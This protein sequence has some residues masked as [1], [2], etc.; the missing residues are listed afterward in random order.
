[1]IIG[2]DPGTKR[3]G[4]A[5]ADEETR[6]AR[7]VEVIEAPLSETIERIKALVTELGASKVVVGRPVNLAGQ[8]G[9][10]MDAH[11]SFI[12]RLRS[13][14]EV[15]VDGYDERLTSVIAERSMREAGVSAK[16]RKSMIDAVA[17]QVML[18]G[19]LDSHG[20]QNPEGRVSDGA[21]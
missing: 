20:A 8:E 3:T 5:A 11:K 19:Y 16:K 21:D 13:E 18:Q 7:P 15:P 2:I 12:V 4:V 10:A 17:A 1:M 9:P 14:I 6:F